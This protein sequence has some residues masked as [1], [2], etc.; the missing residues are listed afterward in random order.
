MAFGSRPGLLSQWPVD[1]SK[2]FA[3]NR[4]IFQQGEIFE[5]EFCADSRWGR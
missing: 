5:R 3:E 1:P 4:G 2:V